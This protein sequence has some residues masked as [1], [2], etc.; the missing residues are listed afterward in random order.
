MT[1]ENLRL[2]KVF[3]DAINF[4]NVKIMTLLDTY[5]VQARS[6][7]GPR[8]GFS[9]SWPKLAHYNYLLVFNIL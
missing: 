9:F 5:Y 6:Q 4:V 3:V 1:H 7:L 2:V 8:V